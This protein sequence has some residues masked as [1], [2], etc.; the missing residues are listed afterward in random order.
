MPGYSSWASPEESD[1]L[2]TL[3]DV[4]GIVGGAVGGF[5]SVSVSMTIT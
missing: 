4:G 1:R 2:S 5:I 3:Y